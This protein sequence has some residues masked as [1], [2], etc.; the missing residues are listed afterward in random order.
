VTP[1]D[2]LLGRYEIV[3]PLAESAQAFVHRARDRATGREVAVK[4][5]RSA[6]PVADSRTAHES[7]EAAAY[8][9][10]SHPNIASLI[11]SGTL[12]DGRLVVVFEFVPGKTLRAILDSEGPIEPAFALRWM[13]EVL[14]ALA[15]AH[16][17]GVVHRDVKPENIMVSC[18]GVVRHAILLDFGLAARTRGGDSLSPPVAG[19]ELLGTPRY[20]APE[21]LRGDPATAR[22]DLYSW[23]LTLIE[24]LAGTAP[25]RGASAREAVAEQLGPGAIP[26]PESWQRTPLARLLQAVTAKDPA[27]RPADAVEAMAIL[28]GIVP[29]IAGPGGEQHAPVG[30]SPAERLMVVVSARI[31]EP[32]A[33][34]AGERLAREYAAVAELLQRGG[35]TVVSAVGRRVT[36]VFGLRGGDARD[37]ARA[38]EAA[39]SLLERPHATGTDHAPLAW[40]IGIHAGEVTAR[41]DGAAIDR[42]ESLLGTTFEV[43]MLLDEAARPGRIAISA[44]M[45]E[46]ARQ[47]WSATRAGEVRVDGLGSPVAVFRLR[48]PRR[49]TPSTDAAATIT[50][51]HAE[52]DIVR[53]AWDATVAGIPRAL[54]ISGPAGIGKSTIVRGA[55]RIVGDADWLEAGCTIERQAVPMSPVIDLVQSL[56][57]PAT[58]LAQRHALTA[59]EAVPVL[60]TLLGEP[61]PDGYALPP[62]TPD[63]LKELT[64]QVVVRL[65]C[66]ISGDGPV[67]VVFEDLQWADPSTLDFLNLLLAT[68]A[69]H[70]APL[71][72]LL[73]VTARDGFVGQWNADVAAHIALEPMRPAEVV[74]M[75][76][77]GMR[78]GRSIREEVVAALVDASGGNPLFVEQATHLIAA[79]TAT[80]TADGSGSSGRI[81]GSLE[82][83]LGAQLGLL[84]EEARRAAQVAGAIGR[85]FDA[86]L[87]GAVTRMR[88]AALRSA[89]DELIEAGLV[90]AAT[91]VAGT[92]FAF[93]HALVR[94]AAY[95]SVP[96]ADR[97][98]VHRNIAAIL[99]RDHPEIALRRP[100]ELA[101]HFEL[102]N[103]A[104]KACDLWHRSGVHAL[105][106]AAYLSACKDLE[107][108]ER[109]LEG[110]PDTP[111]RTM[112]SLGLITALSSAHITTKGFG[113][114]EARAAFLKARQL[115]DKL[116]REIPLE[117]LGGIFGAALVTADREETDAIMPRFRELSLRTDNPL[118]AF[119]GHQVLAVQACWSGRFDEAY[120]HATAGVDL[121]RRE[122]VHG[123]SWEFGF[124]IHCYA[125]LMMV[126][127]HRGF[128]DDAEAIRLE[129][130]RRAETNGNPHCMAVALGWSTTLTHDC[131]RATET[132]EIASRLSRLSEEQHLV[133]WGGYAMLARGSALTALGDPGEAVAC[134][135]RGLAVMEAVGVNTGLCYYT[136]YLV[137]ALLA[138][139]DLDGAMEAVQRG[140]HLNASLWTRLHESEMVRLHGAV[141]ERLDRFEEAGAEYRRAVA[142][143]RR[144]GGRAIELRALVD[145][146]RLPQEAE[147][148][149]R[150]LEEL[151]TAL[152]HMGE[153]NS[154][155]DVRRAREMVA[156]TSTTHEGEQDSR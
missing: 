124:G 118:H 126:Q 122:A 5:A 133:L 63:R 56:G 47:H 105:S 28:A 44:R 127:F 70:D 100:A 66:E 19:S 1:G 62:V 154:T 30:A 110:L 15:A 12:P 148:R 73:V 138:A 64:A 29:Q 77:A 35:G 22:S 26:L 156:A 96:P 18:T 20:A 91:D 60:A 21:Q 140:M 86:R 83:V 80:A 2:L 85:H 31:A 88:P 130:L 112:R 153:G 34:V 23:G 81:P 95:E 24:C 107:R 84:G 144:D 33:D 27:R 97:P 109:L 128:A 143:A 67:A 89:L 106:S 71:P 59:P 150:T 4:I 78:D 45:E 38:L 103:E 129:M 141:L 119:S 147:R 74:E 43:A 116:G 123:I 25:V 146:A 52:L 134:L 120:R 54:F 93:S 121:Y 87:V 42:A 151:S 17:E 142:I 135:R 101:L 139:G 155:I 6:G 82:R 50:G 117:I 55:R 72:I 132:L 40:A 14:D 102:A 137:R 79:R 41:S 16:R 152:R 57:M 104:A 75:I 69:K 9:L 131:G 145:L 90:A 149:A 37:A 32:I 76:R 99:E 58:A 111:E 113:A 8:A 39:S 3:G 10:V 115:C 125:Y 61:I 46:I 7:D 136:A 51:R 49:S 11:A 114:T 65:L 36:A 13:G 92:A 68:I 98:R 94:D 53:D 48:R 108:S